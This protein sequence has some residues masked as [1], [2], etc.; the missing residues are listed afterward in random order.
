M[1]FAANAVAPPEHPPDGTRPFWCGGAWHRR[2]G[3][4]RQAAPDPVPDARVSKPLWNPGGLPYH[5]KHPYVFSVH[6]QEYRVDYLPA[7][8]NTGMFGGNSNWR[9][10]IW[11]PVNVM[12]IRALLQYYLYYGD[13]FKLECPTGSGNLMNLFEVSREI[14]TRLQGIFLRDERGRRPIYGGMEKF[15]TDPHWRDHLLFHEYFHG[16]NGAGLGPAIRRAGRGR[17]RSSSSFTA[18]WIQRRCLK[19]DG[20]RRSCVRVRPKFG[21]IQNDSELEILLRGT[22]NL[23]VWLPT[24]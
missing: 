19:P 21:R 22:V 9:G 18:T 5:A 15:K 1:R 13:N 24:E 20:L 17:W 7:E 16:D 2:L 14:S 8:S 6:G 10:P 11:M 12:L 4:P 3:G 23:S